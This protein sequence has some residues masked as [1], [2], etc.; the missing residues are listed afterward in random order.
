[1]IDA[2][3]EGITGRYAR[4]AKNGD[5]VDATSRAARTTMQCLVNRPQA[6]TRTVVLM[7]RRARRAVRQELRAW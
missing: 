6:A 4:I 7:K 5:E 1:M 2:T 3:R